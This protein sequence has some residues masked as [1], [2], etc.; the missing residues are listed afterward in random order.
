MGLMAMISGGVKLKK[1]NRD[2]PDP[3]VK[4]EV[5]RPAGQPMSMMEELQMRQKRRASAE[6]VATPPPE[7]QGEQHT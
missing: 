2:T 3:R 4:K 1:V 7:Q 6:A 5:V